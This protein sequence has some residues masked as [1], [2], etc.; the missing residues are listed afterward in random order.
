MSPQIRQLDPKALDLTWP[1]A[2]PWLAAGLDQAKGG[3]LDIG[4]LRMLARDGHAVIYVLELGGEFHGAA[5]VQLMRYPNF[6]AAN[7]I[8]I[9]GKLIANKQNLAAWG[10]MLRSLGASKIEGFC[11]EAVA[12]LWKR[13]GFESIY[14]VARA[15]L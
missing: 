12:R 1:K 5:A 3:E 2:A 9:G 13:F 8:S 15:D 14:I 4:Q 11:S 6:T 10:A 7:V